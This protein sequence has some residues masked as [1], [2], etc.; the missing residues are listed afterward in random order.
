M[1]VDRIAVG[2]RI[3]QIMRRMQINQQELAGL[4]GVSQPAISLYLQGRLPPPEVLL[5]IARLGNTSIEWLLTGGG[6]GP[7]PAGSVVR[8]SSAEYS[9]QHPLFRLWNRLPVPVQAHLLGLIREIV[10]KEQ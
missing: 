8:E 2:E 6:S 9:S 5:Q 4:I 1:G 7:A 3:R 10:E